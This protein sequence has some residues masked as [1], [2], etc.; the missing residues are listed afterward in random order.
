MTDEQTEYTLYYWPGIQGRGEF[1]RLT[2]EAAGATYRDIAREPED[3]G[4]GPGAIRDVLEG[5]DGQQ[6]PAFAPP[7]LE[8]DGST[9]AQTANICQFLGRRHGLAGTSQQELHRVH[10]VQLTVHDCLTEAHDTHHPISIAEYYEDQKDAARRRAAFFVEQ[11]IPKFLGHFDAVLGYTD[12]PF[13]LGED[14][15]YGDLAVFQLLEGLNYA[16]PRGY[17]RGAD[18]LND[19]AA[20]REAVSQQP[21][22]K[23]YLD[24]DRR[25]PFNEKGIFRH[26]PELDLS[27]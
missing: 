26:Y 4:G 16:F 2:L 24:S 19:L 27:D 10:Q 5:L 3:Q 13:L 12:G 8:V 11:R 7:V 22:V 1:V 23:A 17:R 20:L 14:L 6:P 25:I 9:Y 15:S 21:G 18:S